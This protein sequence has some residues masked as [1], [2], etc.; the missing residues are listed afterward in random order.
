MK[1]GAKGHKGGGGGG[2]KK[3][4]KM[5]IKTAVKHTACEGG[6]QRAFSNLEPARIVL[7]ASTP[8]NKLIPDVIEIGEVSQ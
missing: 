5:K 3:R 6:L 8:W 2:E 7:T 1:R 4:N